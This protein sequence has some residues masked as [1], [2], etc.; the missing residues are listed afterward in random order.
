MDT[1]P[2]KGL[3][4]LGPKTPLSRLALAGFALSVIGVAAAVMAAEGTRVDWWNFGQ[5]FRILR[6]A[7]YFGLAGTALSLGG[8]IVARAGRGG[9]GFVLALLGMVLGMVA[10]GVPGTWYFMAGR[11]PMIHDISTDTENPPRFVA[12]LPLRKDAPN[13][14]QYGGPEVAAKQ[15]AAYP[16]V[17]PLL[18]ALPPSEAYDISLE[19]ARRME[20]RIVAAEPSEG[21]IEAVATTRWFGFK[22]DVVVRITPA[23]NRGSIIDIRSVSRVGMSDIGTNARRIQSFLKTVADAARKR[24]GN[25]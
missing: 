21:R 22:D 16:D 20:W 5:G 1:T 18:V 7:A 9:R 15:R 11:L 8:A 17:R 19:T 4:P 25:S 23:A 24:S 2:G 3:V 6:A 14:A 10:F 13:P 12:I